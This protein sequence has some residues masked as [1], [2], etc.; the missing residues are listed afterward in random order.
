MHKNKSKI[1]EDRNWYPP[2]PTRDISKKPE[3]GDSVSDSLVTR[4]RPLPSTA[5]GK[6]SVTVALP[7]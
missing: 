5:F 2:I 7:A 1:Y 3:T 4:A 6:E